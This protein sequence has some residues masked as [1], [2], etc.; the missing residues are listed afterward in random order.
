MQK[1]PVY[2]E[3]IVSEDEVEQECLPAEW[4]GLP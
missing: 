2:S 3:T 1:S 4:Q